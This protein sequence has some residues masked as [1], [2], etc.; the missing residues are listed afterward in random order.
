MAEEVEMKRGGEG[1][2]GDM[3]V[4][5]EEEEEEVKVKEGMEENVKEGMEIKRRRRRRKMVWRERWK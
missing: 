2:E 4:K 1:C 3:K 5:D